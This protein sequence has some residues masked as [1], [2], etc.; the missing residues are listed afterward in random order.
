M[1]ILGHTGSGLVCI[2]V[3]VERLTESLDNFLTMF[4]E[5]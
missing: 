4:F 2:L 5:T 3:V 1:Q